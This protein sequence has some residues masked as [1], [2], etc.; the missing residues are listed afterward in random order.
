MRWWWRLALAVLL[1]FGLELAWILADGLTDDA[2][3]ADLIVVLG[4]KVM[5]TGEPHPRLAARLQAALDCYVAGCAPALLVSGGTGHE[6][7]P[8][9]RVMRDWL[10]ARGVPAAVVHVDDAGL[11]TRH[12]ARHAAA[13]M[14]ERGWARA[15]VATQA[16]HVTRCKLALRQ[17][18][19]P[20]VGSVHAR[21]AEPRDVYSLVREAIGLWAYVL[22]LRR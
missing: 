20:D 11:T 5:P 2:A 18:G 1:V 17:A 6:G 16:Y 3:R 9:A 8:E 21:Y 10:V 12:T 7:H 13:L 14:A 19:V 22:G 15:I 4:N